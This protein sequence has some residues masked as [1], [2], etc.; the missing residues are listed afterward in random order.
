[1]PSVSSRSTT[2]SA[3]TRGYARSSS[4][5]GLRPKPGMSR[6]TVRKPAAN[7]AR[8]PLKFDQPLTPGPDPWSSTRAAPS[9][10]SWWWSVKRPCT[11][12]LVA[13][14]SSVAVIVPLGA[15]ATGGLRRDGT[16]PHPHPPDPCSAD[17]VPG[18]MAASRVGGAVDEEGRAVDEGAV[19]GGEGR[20]HAGHFVRLR[21]AP[22]VG[23]EAAEEARV[24]VLGKRDLED[25]RGGD[26][27]RRHAH[28]PH[29]PLAV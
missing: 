23:H 18:R 9:P 22:A 29:V 13:S 27:A 28:G 20:H 17:R 1:M 11:T 16:S 24:G 7:V 8:L 6:S 5:D 3:A 15:G 21:E 25:Q 2:A 12:L 10:A 14:K 26:A 4:T 19:V